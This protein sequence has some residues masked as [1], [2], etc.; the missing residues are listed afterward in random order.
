MERRLPACIREMG[1][2]DRRFQP[3]W[4]NIWNACFQLA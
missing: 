1:R 4:A 2:M 3:A